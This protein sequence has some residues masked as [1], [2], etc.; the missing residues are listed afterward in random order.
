MAAATSLA[1]KPP[2]AP[3]IV[4][5]FYGSVPP[6]EADQEAAFRLKEAL[7]PGVA[8]GVGELPRS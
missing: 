6:C 7:D 5:G 2:R 3:Q 4:A 1:G 8:W